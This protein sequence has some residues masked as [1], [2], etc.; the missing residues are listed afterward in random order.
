MNIVLDA[1]TLIALLK[2]EAGADIVEAFLE[3]PQHTC[4]IHAVNVCEVFYKY[5]H[6]TDAETVETAIADLSR[7]GIDINR[8][9]DD[10]FSREVGQLKMKLQS[11]S[12]ADCFCVALA[13]RLGA[14]LLTADRPDFEPDAREGLCAVQFIR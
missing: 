7:S 6:H 8:D 2:D 12:L 5:A 9:L 3:D 1:S 14:T 11:P 13:I 10:K 4:F